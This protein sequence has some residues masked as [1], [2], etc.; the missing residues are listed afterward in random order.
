[1]NTLKRLFRWSL[2]AASVVTMIVFVRETSLVGF[3]LG[4]VISGA[5]AFI[6]TTLVA[7]WGLLQWTAAWRAVRDSEKQD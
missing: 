2:V 5:I 7:F 6:G 4:I 1:M 3:S